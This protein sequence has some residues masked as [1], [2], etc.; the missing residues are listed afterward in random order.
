MNL[1]RKER[2]NEFQKYEYISVT[3]KEEMSA[4]TE[5]SYQAFGWERIEEKKVGNDITFRLRRNR[6]M[7]RRSELAKLQQRMEQVLIALDRLIWQITF[8]PTMVAISIGL[9]GSGVIAAAIISLCND[10]KLLFAFLQIPGMAVCASALFVYFH[11]VKIR[12]ESRKTEKEQLYQQLDQ[13]C[14][15]GEEIIES[16]GG[17]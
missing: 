11:M 17:M 4:I 8:I 1:T 14:H 15:Q 6:Q 16:T 2:E 13:V 3:V 5:N 9:A 7:K 10:H 12:R